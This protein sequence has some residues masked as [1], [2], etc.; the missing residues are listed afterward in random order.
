MQS[1]SKIQ[2]QPIEEFIGRVRTA[3]ARQDKIINLPIREAEKLSDSLAQTM[4]RLAEHL[5]LPGVSS[6]IAHL[7]NH[8]EL[9]RE[10]MNIKTISCIS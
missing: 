5:K 6:E 2:T 1:K 7:V 8:K 3:K 10:K 9:F 4:T